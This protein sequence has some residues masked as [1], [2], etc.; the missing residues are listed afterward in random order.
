MKLLKIIAKNFRILFRSKT[1]ALVII[2]GPLF[3]MV[4]VGLAFSNNSSYAVDV[5]VYS[6]SFNDLTNSFVDSL[7]DEFGVHRY[8]LEAD[9]IDD[10]KQR[11]VHACVV[12]PP[13]MVIDD[14]LENEIVFWVD[15]SNI[16]LAWMVS[17]SISDV[18]GSESGELSLGMT[19]ILLDRLNETQAKLDSDIKSLENLLNENKDLSSKSSSIEEEA[20]DISVP[21]VSNIVT[22][23]STL[24]TDLE[25]VKSDVGGLEGSD[26]VVDDIDDI[27]GDVDDVSDD[28]SKVSS[29]L[30]SVSSSKEKILDEVDSIGSIIS[31]S[32]SKLNSI[33]DSS[34]ALNK[35]I[36]DVDVKS[37][38]SIVSPVSTRIEP[39]SADST[40]L[41]FLFPALLVL[42]VMLVSVLLASS[43]SVSEKLNL[44]LFRNALAPTRRIM[45]TLS[46]FLTCFILLTVQL[47]II[48]LISGYFFNI[49]VLSNLGTVSLVLVVL[50]VLFVILGMFIGSL[51]NSTEMNV[52]S[53]V[54]VCAVL[55]LLS[56]II[57]PLEGIP[58]YLKR[59]F[60]F[61]PF[62]IGESLL[63]RSLLF[64]VQVPSLVIP[65]G[66]LIVYAVGLFIVMVL[67]QKLLAAR[68]LH[69][70]ARRYALK[71]DRE[72]I[73]NEFASMFNDIKE[74]QYFKL[75][76][77]TVIKNLNDMVAALE[78]MDNKVF[79][80]YCN[81]RKNDFANWAKH[82]L[83]NELLANELSK[84]SGREDLLAR[85]KMHGGSVKKEEKRGLFGLRRKKQKVK[86]ASEPDV[87]RPKTPLHKL[88]SKKK[89][90]SDDDEY[91]EIS[92]NKHERKESGGD[93]ERK[94]KEIGT[95]GSDALDM[96]DDLASKK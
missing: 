50:V 57:I 5:G 78:G 90:K 94:Q 47:V 61:N 62:V 30:S 85:L 51:F 1:S 4:L 38:V 81:K 42:V 64:N 86:V 87:E 16:N 66:V 10:V 49:N 35:K 67:L 3:L 89:H 41:N 17:K 79:S 54:S 53:S 65:L 22:A 83:R 19:A 84:I 40:H 15:Q 20:S 96:A 18:I 2:L 59:F 14:N 60:V 21:S 73:E 31:G 12:F 63:K 43:L 39:V 32:V 44:A 52:L 28:L 58:A 91:V 25:S 36:D 74:G 56:G 24:K 45:F 37:A 68:F 75:D 6:S 9:C 8:S 46:I 33:K 29:S 69:F 23:L 55:L 7:G 76:D 71:R 11:V 72:R 82:V 13:D 34:S 88:K 80:R 27:I 77:G 95:K 48:M 26:E 70:S 92:V 93:G